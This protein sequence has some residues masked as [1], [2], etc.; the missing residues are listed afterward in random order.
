MST[1]PLPLDHNGLP[2]AILPDPGQ[3]R[4]IGI[5]V[6]NANVNTNG[7]I[8]NSWFLAQ[9]L[10]RIGYRVDF[11]TEEEN[12]DKFEATQDPVY[13]LNKDSTRYD[14]YGLIIYGS[15]AISDIEH[16][17]R[18]K[19]VGTRF[20]YFNCGNYYMFHQ[21]EFVFGKV[22]DQSQYVMMR[23]ICNFIDEIW[24][25]PSYDFMR[26][27]LETLT[28]RRV[29]DIPH[30]WTNEMIEKQIVRGTPDALYYHPNRR[31]IDRIE[32]IILEPN[33]NI[34]KTSWF[35]LVIAERFH[36]LF[37]HIL[38]RVHLFC[39][40]NHEYSQ[41]MIGNLEIQKAG[42]LTVY[43][44]TPMPIILNTFHQRE[45]LPIF[46]SHQ[47]LNPLNYIY[48]E[49]MYYGFPLVHNSDILRDHCYYYPDVNL[50]AGVEA[51]R[52]AHLQYT[53][54][55]TAMYRRN[56]QY[57]EQTNMYSTDNLNRLHDCVQ[58]VLSKPML[59]DMGRRTNAEGK[60]EY[61]AKTNEG[62]NPTGP[63][64]PAIGG[65]SPT[66]PQQQP[67]QQ[68]QPQLQQGAA[69]AA[70]RP[71]KPPVRDRRENA[72]EEA[73]KAAL[74]IAASRSTTR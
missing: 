10:R 56:H 23:V 52:Q 43:E 5:T 7:N 63:I 32:L 8:T 24:Q 71:A 68:P 55:F 50:D 14:E 21:E 12:F 74:S 66:Q 46:L 25:I 72:R 13:R 17:Y 37:P 1:N 30:L 22:R 4:R 73:R 36:Q 58:S 3:C 15:Y 9:A 53:H 59:V 26:P 19:Q 41:V 62:T 42:K 34:S 45:C 60:V 44:R 49:L 57:I 16:I 61:E 70:A 40:R 35:P 2:T 31:R 33:V 27:Y 65:T 28:H 6:R 18:F 69:S 11:L 39:F 64:S 54:E 51:V 67:Q 29:Y 20:V 38:D 48:Y 47:T